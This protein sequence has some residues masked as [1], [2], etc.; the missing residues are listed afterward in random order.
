MRK[1][2]YLH[3]LLFAIAPAIFLW[4]QNFAEA[5]IRETIPAIGALIVFGALI[6][7]CALLLYRNSRKA[8]ILTSTFL[9]PT[10]FFEQIFFNDTTVRFMKHSWAFMAVFAIVAAVGYALGRT[11]RNLASINKTL[12]VV[13]G[14]FVLLSLFQLG[15]DFYGSI[16]GAESSQ[17]KIPVAEIGN[18]V[19]SFPDIY[20]IIFDEY[21][22]PSVIKDTL[23]VDEADEISNWL[24]EKGFFVPENSRSNYQTTKFSIPSSLNMRYLTEEE[25]NNKNRL[26]QLTLDHSLKDALE[27]YGYNHIN[28][29]AQWVNYHNPYADENIKYSHDYLSP[30]QTAL[31]Q[32]TIFS[33]AG[34]ALDRIFNIQTSP[35]LDERIAHWHRVQFKFD[36]LAEISKREDGPNFVFAHFLLPHV[37][38]TFDAEGNYVSRFTSA[39]LSTTEKY[40]DQVLFTNKKIK[41]LVEK[42]LENS[43]TPPIII[44]QGDHGWRELRNPEIIKKL[45][46]DPTKADELTFHIFNAYYLPN[47]GS[48]TLYETISPVNTFRA[49]L[50]Y[51][52]GQDLKLLKD[53][54]YVIDLSDDPPPSDF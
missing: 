17:N 8:A 29:G 32:T 3:P 20:Y 22:A 7:G 26:T 36:E 10:L 23:K 15:A 1:A 34:A 25:L 2:H 39:K 5:P 47:G 30:F 12:V 16:K 27:T 9:F 43:K 49:I 18:Q 4:E 53:A 48:G 35:I 44:M 28:F 42:I 21:A 37:P 13:S 40:I 50:N 54:S 46:L 14:A 19:K 45:E 41:E 11:R 52:F 6:F 33:K 51:Y 38:D 24:E 31:W